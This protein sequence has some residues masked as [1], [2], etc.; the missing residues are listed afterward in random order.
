MNRVLLRFARQKRFRL[1]TVLFLALASVLTIRCGPGAGDFEAFM[2]MPI[3]AK[4]MVVKLDGNWGHDPWR[5]WEL[6]P[7]D[8]VLK[9][10]L[11]EMWKLAPDPKA[12]HGV[13]S[14]NHIYCRFDDLSESY[15]AEGSDSYRAVGVDAQKAKLVVYFYNG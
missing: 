1:W 8:D 2:G 12:F 9:R 6:S 15:S 4:V 7:V 13:A 10:K 11:I 3:T 5:C 14:G